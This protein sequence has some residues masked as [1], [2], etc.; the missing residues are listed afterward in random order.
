LF[1]LDI[2]LILETPFVDEGKVQ[3]REIKLLTDMAELKMQ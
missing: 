3:M 1:A 2:P